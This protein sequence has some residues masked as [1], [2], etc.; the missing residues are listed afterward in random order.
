VALPCLSDGRGLL[1][2]RAVGQIEEN[3]PGVVH[4][5]DLV[6]KFLPLMEPKVPYTVTGFGVGIWH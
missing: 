4:F 1:F 3:P 6:E 5:E 2:W